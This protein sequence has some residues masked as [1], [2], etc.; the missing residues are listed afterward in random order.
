[1]P[2]VL[3]AGITQE[4]GSQRNLDSVQRFVTN[5]LSHP[6]KP[7]WFYARIAF[8]GAGAHVIIVRIHAAE[9]RD[10]PVLNAVESVTLP[11]E[12]RPTVEVK[13]H[14]KQL[15]FNRFGP[16][17]LVIGCDDEILQVIQ[18]DVLRSTPGPATMQ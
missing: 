3:T 1:M 12:S 10:M 17:E 11:D 14:I 9:D 15:R 18:L 2:K 16:H 5:D 6:F 4:L 13:I 8:E 7:C